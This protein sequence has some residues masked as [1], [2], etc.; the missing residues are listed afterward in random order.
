VSARD[1]TGPGGRSW[2]SRRARMG[3]VDDHGAGRLADLR[4]AGGPLGPFDAAI[5]EAGRRAP[6]CTGRLLRRLV[7]GKEPALLIVD[8][9]EQDVIHRLSQRTR[10]LSELVR[11]LG[12]TIGG[13]MAPVSELQRSKGDEA[14]QDAATE[15]RLLDETPNELVNITE[16]GEAMRARSTFT[17]REPSRLMDRRAEGS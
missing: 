9:G 15:K 5:P 2:R 16:L 1:A 12:V 10:R 7:P 11:S 3:A 4:D 17:R 8:E 14:E 6:G 13:V